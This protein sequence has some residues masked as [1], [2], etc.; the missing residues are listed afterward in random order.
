M[1]N[2]YY[3]ATGQNRQVEL[4]D[5][6]NEKMYY[7]STGGNKMYVLRH[8]YEDYNG[9]NRVIRDW[10][11]K[12]L[13][14]N[15]DVAIEKAKEWVKE[16]GEKNHDLIINSDYQEVDPNDT[17]PQWVKDIKKSNQIEKD[18]AK[19]RLKKWEAEREK[20]LLEQISTSWG[21]E[22]SFGRGFLEWSNEQKQIIE[23]PSNKK[24]IV[25]AGPGTG[26]TATACARIS[27]LIDNGVEPSNIWL[28]SFTRTAVQELRDRIANFS[29]NYDDISGVTISTVDSRA[30][31]IREGFKK[32]KTLRPWETFEEQKEVHSKDL[33]DEINE[34]LDFE[35]QTTKKKRLVKKDFVKVPPLTEV[36]KEEKKRKIQEK[37]LT[38]EENKKPGISSES[39]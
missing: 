11:V 7:Y 9:Y 19:E 15:I 4:Y 26:K 39:K 28:L 10:Y 25:N 32:E 37:L 24:I 38:L 8:T 29:E 30:W 12:T 2:Y 21:L 1:T 18:K 13:S 3:I 14:K 35:K 16:N 27:H 5:L 31:Y 34:R 23:M 33:L 17:I 36:E 6:A 22:F 20:K